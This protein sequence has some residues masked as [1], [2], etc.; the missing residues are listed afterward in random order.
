[1]SSMKSKIRSSIR[2]EIL[3]PDAKRS[4]VMAWFRTSM[5]MMK[6]KGDK[7]QS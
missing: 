2:T 6:R 1:M 5:T 3:M 4:E 7:D